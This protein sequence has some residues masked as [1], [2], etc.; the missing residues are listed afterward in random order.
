MLFEA[1]AAKVC[2]GW[3][4]EPSVLST[5][6]T[7]LSALVMN[8]STPSSSTA[9]SIIIKGLFLNNPRITASFL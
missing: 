3:K 4:T 6:D 8:A 9:T 5:H 7:D 1:F 2:T